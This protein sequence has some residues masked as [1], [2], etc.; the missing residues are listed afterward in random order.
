MKRRKRTK[1]TDVNGVRVYYYAQQERNVFKIILMQSIR[2]RGFEAR[3]KQPFKII[4]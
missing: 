3:I 1:N 4:K 2:L